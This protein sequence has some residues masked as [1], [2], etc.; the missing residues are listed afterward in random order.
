[1]PGLTRVSTVDVDEFGGHVHDALDATAALEVRRTVDLEEA[2]T[3][4]P[5][6][7]M[8]D[9]VVVT[10]SHPGLPLWNTAASLAAGTGRTWLPITRDGLTVTVGPL[11]MGERAPCFECAVRRRVQHDRQ[12]TVKALLTEAYAT[13]R[14]PLPGGFLP[15][16]VRMSAAATVMMLRAAAPGQIASIDLRQAAVSIHGVV[17]C[18]DCRYCARPTNRGVAVL[19]RSLAPALGR[20]RHAPAEVGR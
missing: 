18:D 4:V 16:H 20:D 1:M 15:H 12:K 9:V 8:A 2:F 6:G 14:A 19:R 10:A 3:P 13:G 7:R 11:V 17:E 5:P